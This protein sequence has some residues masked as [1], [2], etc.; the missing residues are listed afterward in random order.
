MAD[1]ILSKR[2][3]ERIRRHRKAIMVV[4]KMRAKKVVVAQLRAQGLKVHHYSARDIALLTE[5]YMA[6]HL[7]PLINKAAEDVATWP[8]FA[9]QT[10]TQPNSIT[11]T[12]QMS[13]AE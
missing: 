13:G 7:E 2:D 9:A 10:Q 6:Q 1:S 4:A 12:V 8:E 5:D 11:S 3:V